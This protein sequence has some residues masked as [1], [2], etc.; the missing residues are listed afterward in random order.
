MSTF[1]FSNVINGVNNISNMGLIYKWGG[2]FTDVWDDIWF[3]SF[4]STTTY[5]ESNSNEINI[6]QNSII[7]KICKI[8]IKS[9]TIRWNCHFFFPSALSV[10]SFLPLAAS[11]FAFCSSSLFFAASSLCFRIIA[12]LARSALASSVF[13]SACNF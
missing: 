5:L 7:Q 12:S 6:S 1:F 13:P 4:R 3:R 11:S 2:I 9:K 10:V 8:F